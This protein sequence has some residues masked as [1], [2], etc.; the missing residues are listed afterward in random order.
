MF[1]TLLKQM[2]EGRT[3]PVHLVVDGLA[4]HKTRQVKDYVASTEG[5]L[6]LDALP[7]YAPDLNS[8]DWSGAT[9]NAQG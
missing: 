2:M 4:A 9:S 6:T 7:G 1:F 8:D 5:M 3:K